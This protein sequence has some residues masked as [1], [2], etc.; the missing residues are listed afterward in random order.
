[1]RQVSTSPDVIAQI[2][3]MLFTTS[4]SPRHQSIYCFITGTH[5][6]DI[7]TPKA[8]NLPQDPSAI[9]PFARDR[10]FIQRGDTLAYL[11]HACDAPDSRIALVGLGGVG[12]VA[13]VKDLRIAANYETASHR[14][15]LNMRTKSEKDP[16][17]PGSFGSTPVTQ[18]VASKAFEK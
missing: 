9:I 8:H 11:H 14:L 12:Q 15:P 10:D 4:C 16:L 6:D 7:S 17:K 18:H 3:T 1:M 13:T 5:A 2:F